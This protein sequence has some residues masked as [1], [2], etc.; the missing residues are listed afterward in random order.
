[1]SVRN[2]S[3]NYTQTSGTH[4]PGFDPQAGILGQDWNLMAPGTAFIFG[5][6]DDIRHQAA[7]EGWLVQYEDIDGNIVPLNIPYNQNRSRNLTARSQ[8]EPFRDLRIEVTAQRSHSRTQ[9]EYFTSVD[10]QY[11]SFNPMETG[12][13][14]ISFFALGTTFESIDDRTYESEN[15][16]NLKDYRYDIAM[17]LANRN[18]NWDGEVND[19]TGFPTGYGPTSQDVLI[20]AF[21]AAY[22]G[23]DPSSS[24]LDP[25][26]RFPMPN[27]R[28]T[29]DGLSR[30]PAFQR[31]FQ[32]FTIG[33]GYQS[34]F[35]IGSFSRTPGIVNKTATKPQK[36]R[37]QETSFLNSKLDRYPSASSS[38]R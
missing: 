21:I 14:S 16:E 5:S 19:T 11:E 27:W 37:P 1:M 18:P 12:N 10:G 3:I 8:V 36:V 25:F 33:H 17:R 28:L 9:S 13:F 29:Y 4:M 7:R 35:T 30:L 31:L 26:L 23:R 24:T 6:Q 20:P 22:S 34:S 38:T 32:S 2:L 15:F